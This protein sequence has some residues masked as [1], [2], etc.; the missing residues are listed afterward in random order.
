MRMWNKR[1]FC[2][3]NS[4]SRIRLLSILML[5]VHLQTIECFWLVIV[6]RTI[7]NG[8][9]C[10]LARIKLSWLSVLVDCSFN[11]SSFNSFIIYGFDVNWCSLHASWDFIL[12]VKLTI[13]YTRPQTGWNRF[14]IYWLWTWSLFDYLCYNVGLDRSISFNTFI[15]VQASWFLRF[16]LSFFHLFDF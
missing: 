2:D 16:R 14:L 12:S 7:L 15:A 8:T 13:L 10:V 4:V 6:S 11:S 1:W 3:T 9:L 5:W